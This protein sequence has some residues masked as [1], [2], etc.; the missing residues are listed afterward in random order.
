[1]RPLLAL[2]GATRFATWDGIFRLIDFSDSLDQVM[3]QNEE[4][5]LAALLFADQRTGF[6]VF[7]RSVTLR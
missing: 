5:V 2:P 3:G 1:M 4:S 7:A 6:S